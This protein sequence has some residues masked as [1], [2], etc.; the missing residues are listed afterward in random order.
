MVSYILSN[1]HMIDKF[2]DKEDIE[3]DDL[4]LMFVKYKRF[5]ILSFPGYDLI[6][7]L[8]STR[9]PSSTDGLVFRRYS[10]DGTMLRLHPTEAPPLSKLA[11]Y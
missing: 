8:I 2:L 10:V 9:S 7:K 4:F 5:H 3:I 1:T 11:I 6:W